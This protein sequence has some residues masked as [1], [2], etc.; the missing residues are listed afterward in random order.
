MKNILLPL[1]FFWI[2]YSAKSQCHIRLKDF[3]TKS[4]I[5]FASLSYDQKTIQ[6]NENGIIKLACNEHFEGIISH[7]SYQKIFINIESFTKDTLIYLKSK[8][9]LLNDVPVYA[10][11]NK[12]EIINRVNKKRNHY[13]YLG[14]KYIIASE[15][16]KTQNLPFSLER[17]E[18]PFVRIPGKKSIN[19]GSLIFEL[20]QETGGQLK[21]I[22]QNHV[23]DVKNLKSNPIYL[24]YD[25]LQLEKNAKIYLSVQREL[26]LAPSNSVHINPYFIIDPQ[27][28]E[29]HSMTKEKNQVWKKT[30]NG[31]GRLCKE[32]VLK[33]YGNYFEM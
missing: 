3:D 28:Y 6:A 29:C 20:I 15:I 2:S 18:I 30:E 22:G 16:I 21:P 32:F 19:D 23:I 25:Q 8:N 9:I 13:I 24:T 7:V 33:A 14:T 12:T 31:S 11:K 5:S 27:K 4:P 1:A 10:K 17:I 26:K